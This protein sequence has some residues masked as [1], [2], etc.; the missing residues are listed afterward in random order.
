MLADLVIIPIG[1]GT[2]TSASLANVLR[3][4]KQSGLPYQLNPTSTSVEG[5]WDQIVSLA[6]HCHDAVRAEA[7][8]LVTMLRMEEDVGPVNKLSENVASVEVEAGELFAKGQ[9][10]LQGLA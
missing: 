1:S 8:H 4:I 7:P 2:H 6:K 3:I 5:S 9:A 10:G